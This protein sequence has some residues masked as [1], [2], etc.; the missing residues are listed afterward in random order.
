MTLW[1][2][3]SIGKRVP[4]L[5][6]LAVSVWLLTGTP[7]NGQA[8]SAPATSTAATK[9][10]VQGVQERLQALGYQ[11]GSTDGV[12]GARTA[13][14][15]KKFQ[16]D[17]GL[18]V[19]G[20]PDRE[21][22]DALSTGN[23]AAK[24]STPAAS[25]ATPAEASPVPPTT[26]SPLTLTVKSTEVGTKFTA[27]VGG[28]ANIS[29]PP[30]LPSMFG[31][32]GGVPMI[33]ISNGS[34]FLA[35][36][37]SSRDGSTKFIRISLTVSNPTQDAQ[38]FKIGDVALVS[39][40]SRVNDFAAVGYGSQLCAMGDADRKTVKKI[41]VDV[42]PGETASLSYLFPLMDA[43]ATHG[44]LALGHSAPVTFTIDSSP[45]K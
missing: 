11:P 5:G 45:D 14:A 12:M 36:E 31:G 8:A 43:D 32:G 39:G 29:P 26:S 7:A 1:S 15:L 42:A 44:Q 38:S 40:K 18:P 4:L 25:S 9:K 35:G 22:T 23:T 2:A 34:S 20:I 21:T 16:S 33:S 30:S 17:H 19:T 3:S 28:G 27:Y 10:A 13:A 37:V 6:V 24:S 41:V